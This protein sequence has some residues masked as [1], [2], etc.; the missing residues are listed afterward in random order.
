MLTLP[1]TQ[2][3][4]WQPW[5]ATQDAYL[6]DCRKRGKTLLQ[7]AFL[8][9]R[10]YG[11]VVERCRRLGHGARKKRVCPLDGGGL[12]LLAARANELCWDAETLAA[13]LVGKGFPDGWRAELI[14][15]A[16][17]VNVMY[18]ALSA[19]RDRELER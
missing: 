6:I 13:L 11:S 14:A 16:T 19:A 4:T 9:K 8:T 18:A 15:M 10:P 3:R 5:T 1:T 17:R 7:I 12:V 2:R